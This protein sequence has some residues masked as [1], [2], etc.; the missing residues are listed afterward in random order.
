MFESRHLKKLSFCVGIP[1]NNV[2]QNQSRTIP[3]PSKRRLRSAAICLFI[4]VHSPR[5]HFS[6]VF[7]QRSSLLSQGAWSQFADDVML[8]RPALR[9]AVSELGRGMSLNHF[10]KRVHLRIKCN[11][12]SKSNLWAQSMLASHHL[13]RCSRSASA[14]L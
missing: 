3:P 8:H 14:Y 13:Q 5:S 9:P 6:L 1:I 11:F 2:R 12:Y 4:P 10:R 7:I